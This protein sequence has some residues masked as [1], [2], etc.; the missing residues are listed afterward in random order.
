MS[1]EPFRDQE[2]MPSLRSCLVD[3]RRMLPYGRAG[4]SAD[5][6]G[7]TVHSEGREE[8]EGQRKVLFKIFLV[9]P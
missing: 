7:Y 9:L 8:A 3:G 4:I 1:C 2:G 5:G 6:E